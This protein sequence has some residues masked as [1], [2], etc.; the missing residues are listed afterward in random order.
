MCLDIITMHTCTW[1]KCH[2]SLNVFIYTSQ[3]EQLCTSVLFTPSCLSA[4]KFLAITLCMCDDIA[5]KACHNK[6]H[7]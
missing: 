6:T 3:T 4:P 2:V 5:V 7:L 1:C